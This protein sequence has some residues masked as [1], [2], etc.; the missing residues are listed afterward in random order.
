[1]DIPK[2][3]AAYCEL[4]GLE[5]GLDMNR[6]RSWFEW[7]KKGFT[8]EDLRL[9][10]LEI[11]KGIKIGKRNP[12]ALKF[13]NLIEGL[14]YFEEDLAMVKAQKRAPKFRFDKSATLRAS[15]RPDKPKPPEAQPA[16]VA[17]ERLKMAD[18]LKTWRQSS[19]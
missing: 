14:D 13:R 10:I 3:H 7:A 2:L 9:V 12:G 6:E 11:R 1:M 4:T 15:G 18:M 5:I 19:L 16:S 17:V 8:E